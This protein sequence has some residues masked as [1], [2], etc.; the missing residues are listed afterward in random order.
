MSIEL[1]NVLLYHIELSNVLLYHMYGRGRWSGEKT[2][3]SYDRSIFWTRKWIPGVPSRVYH[4]LF[5]HGTK[6][7]SVNPRYYS[8]DTHIISESGVGCFSKIKIIEPTPVP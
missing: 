3:H 5:I 4:R 8:K 1:S 7:V 6:I 2:R